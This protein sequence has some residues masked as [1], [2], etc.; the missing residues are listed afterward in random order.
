MNHDDSI[1]KLKQDLSLIWSEVL[2]HYDQGVQH[3]LTDEE[4]KLREQSAQDFTDPHPLT[5]AVLDIAE[6]LK[7]PITTARII[8]ELY[9]SP[10]LTKDSNKYLDKSTRQ[11]QNIIND[12]LQSNGFEYG[13]RKSPYSEKRLRGWW[14]SSK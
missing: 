1:K 4:E 13:R 7:A 9:S 14:A 2:Y 11:N 10:D 8:E 12:I 3:Y 6:R 5:D